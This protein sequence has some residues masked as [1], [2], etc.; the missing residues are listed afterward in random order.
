MAEINP[1]TSSGSELIK[2]HQHQNAKA[3]QILDGQSRVQFLY[4]ASSHAK[5]GDPAQ[6]TEF[7]YA[8][9]TSTLIV[10]W[11]ET[12]SQWQTIW[13]ADFTT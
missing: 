11:K 6:L 7:I 3:K 2:S 4:V 5:N 10:A 12:N 1:V 13:D 8:S 9:P